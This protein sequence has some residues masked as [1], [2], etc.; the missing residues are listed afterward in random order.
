MLGKESRYKPAFHEGNNT[1]SWKTWTVHA[2]WKLICYYTL[3]CLLKLQVPFSHFISCWWMY[4]NLNGAISYICNE[5]QKIIIWLVVTLIIRWDGVSVWLRIHCIYCNSIYSVTYIGFWPEGWKQWMKR[6][7]MLLL[8]KSW[9]HT[10]KQCRCK[11]DTPQSDFMFNICSSW[12]MKVLV[13]L[14]TTVMG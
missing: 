10:R 7:L 3:L 9:H 5:W 11:C 14:K 6:S 1:P 2:R 8:H 12:K 4:I 13:K